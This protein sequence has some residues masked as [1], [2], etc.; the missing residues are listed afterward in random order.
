MRDRRQEGRIGFDKNA[1]GRR[2]GAGLAN[3]VR[4]L[5]GD[6]ARKR[7]VEA[8]VEIAACMLDVA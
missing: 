7:K 5:E 3:V 8:E 2:V 1:I 6:D 4:F